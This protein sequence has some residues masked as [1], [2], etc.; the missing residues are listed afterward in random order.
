M[1][2]MR[3]A[4]LLLVVGL[5]ACGG[6]SSDR[7]AAP[8]ARTPGVRMSMDTLHRLGGVP[9]G[10]KLTPPAGDVQAGR[11]AFADFGCP[12]CHKVEGEAF[13]AKAGSTQ[14]GPDLTGMGAHHPPGYFAEA[15]LNPDAVLIEGPG[16]IGP[17]GH[18]VMPD[19]PE[20]TTRQLGDLVA[21][22]SSLTTGGAHAGHVMPAQAVIPANLSARPAPPTSTA[23][24]FFVQSYDVRPDKLA[25]FEAWWKRE[26]AR[27]FLAFDGLLSVDTY[28][29]YTRAQNPFTSIFGFRDMAALQTFMADPGAEQL[30]LEFDGFIG[31][32]GHVSQ[33]WPPI[34]RVST[35]SAP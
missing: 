22:L 16:Y 4:A 13:S 14:V 19:Y 5:A 15:I 30:G 6:P 12:S 2:R 21:Y 20:M 28:A 1:E 7:A 23:K 34:Y 10:W 9:P 18:S 3:S 8:R 29:D 27:R 11:A 25:P 31:D 24:A 17:D 35:L 32:H 33:L 26:G